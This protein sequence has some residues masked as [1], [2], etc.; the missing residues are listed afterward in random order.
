MDPSMR[1]G[2]SWD[3]LEACHRGML[4]FNNSFI[5]LQLRI[6]DP[7]DPFELIPIQD[8]FGSYLQQPTNRPFHCE[9]DSDHTSGSGTL[10]AE[11]ENE[12]E[13]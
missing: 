10:S 5:R 9:C 6:Q 7:R 11:K 8:E 3:V 1:V 13:P 4:S 12:E 2:F